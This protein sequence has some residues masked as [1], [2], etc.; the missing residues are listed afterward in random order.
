MSGVRG[1]AGIGASGMYDAFEDAQVRV[2]SDQPVS[3]AQAK[4]LAARI[5]R[6]YAS[7]SSLQRWEDHGPL[8]QQLTVA[9]LSPQHFADFTGDTTGAI[10]GVTTGPNTIVVPERVLRGTTLDDEDTLAHELAHVQ[11]FREAGDGIASVPTYLEE[12]KAYVLG[13]AYAREPRH[14]ADVARTMAALSADDVAYLLKNFRQASA[15]RRPPQFVYAGEV[16]GALF[17]E[18]LATHVKRDAVVRLCDAV[19]A[20]GHGQRFTDAFKKSFGLS[21]PAV[22]QRF[23]D[24]VRETEGE[25]GRRLAGTLY[26]PH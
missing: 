24:F 23:V 6:A 2:E 8:R 16:M 1:A 7:D 11:D 4:A 18:Y 21:L 22:E 15:E 3:R 5:E 25:P 9:V 17:V 13:D 20:T 26:A 19:E 14:L 10:A 12:G